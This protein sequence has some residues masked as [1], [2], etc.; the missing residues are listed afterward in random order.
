M[1]PTPRRTIANWI[2]KAGEEISLETV[3]KSFKSC[4]LNLATDG[5]ED[6][7]I[8][9]FKEGQ[10]CKADILFK[11]SASRRHSVKPSL[12]SLGPK[13]YKKMDRIL[14]LIRITVQNTKIIKK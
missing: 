8:R 7:L 13:F 9:C 1:K 11:E 10:T 5:L 3:N 12:K 14:Y 4:A 6:N 2:L